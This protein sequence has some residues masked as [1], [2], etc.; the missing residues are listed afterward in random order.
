MHLSSIVICGPGKIRSENQDNFYLN[1]IIR[2]DPSDTGVHR[3]QNRAH[4]C[5]LYAVAD[6]MGGERHGEMASWIAVRELDAVDRESGCAG[7]AGYLLDRN[8]E[9]CRFIEN[10]GGERSG[11]TFVGLLIR[12]DS[13]D[14]V[15][16]GDSRA[17]LLRGTRLHQISRDHT[18]VRQMLELGTIS[19]E[20]LRT[21][22]DRHKLTQHLGIFPDELIIEPYTAIGDLR[23]DDVLL[24]CSD[25]L[26]DMVEDERI[27][28]LLLCSDSISDKAAALY[29]E[30]M[31]NGGRDNI[32][33]LI[34]KVEPAETPEL[35]QTI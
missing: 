29:S 25:G 23:E 34:V 21:H 30:A 16:I 20:Q 5:G 33:V 18:V 35:D 2:N 9:I 12:N 7:V 32:T 31:Q 8:A 24:L 14:L 10:N 19:K 27:R 28:E 15:N 22:P 17:Y 3:I 6:G 26:Y 4:D 13:A 1:G 11:T